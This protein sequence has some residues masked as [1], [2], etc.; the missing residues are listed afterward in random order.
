M[1]WTNLPHSKNIRCPYCADGIDFRLM[2]RQGGTDS[3]VCEACGHLSLPS[4]PFYQC[5]CKNCGKLETKRQLFST[6]ALPLLVPKAGLLED[7]QLRFK[8]LSN[9]F[10]RMGV[11]LS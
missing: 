3:Y 11:L 5:I 4:S 1:N 7:V 2:V 10:R 9:L 8:H 6:A